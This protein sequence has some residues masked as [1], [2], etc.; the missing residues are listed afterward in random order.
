MIRLKSLLKETIVK[1]DKRFNDELIDRI[2]D[3]YNE[4]YQ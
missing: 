2:N 3:E 4:E 1:I